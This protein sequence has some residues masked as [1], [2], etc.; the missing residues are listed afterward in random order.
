MNQKQVKAYVASPLTAKTKEEREK[1]IRKA[2]AYEKAVSEQFGCRAVAPHGY[3]P[4]IID[5][6]VPEERRMAMDFGIKILES[7]D[8]LV[9]CGDTISPG[10]EEE[11]R[12]AVMRSMPIVSYKENIDDY[13]EK[14]TKITVII[15]ELG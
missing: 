11:I 13:L 2:R 9:V 8:I 1:N 3:L 14:K 10:M 5:D 6:T 12:Y 7:C 15:E 4:Y